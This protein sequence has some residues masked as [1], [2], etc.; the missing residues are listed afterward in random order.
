MFKTHY[1][2]LSRIIWL[3]YI[4]VNFSIKSV[5]LH[6]SHMIGFKEFS[7]CKLIK[8]SVVVKLIRDADVG[9]EMYLRSVALHF[10]H[11]NVV[12]KMQRTLHEY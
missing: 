3:Q 4:D 2:S 12:V 11:P 10:Y 6:L 9:A 8:R 7:V 5:I 1:I